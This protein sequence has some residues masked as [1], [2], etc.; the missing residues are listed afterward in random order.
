[1]S[2][3]KNLNGLAMFSIVLFILFLYFNNNR[4]GF[5]IPFSAPNP[6]TGKPFAPRISPAQ[7][8]ANEAAR[9]THEGKTN[10]GR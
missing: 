5:S 4:E 3:K 10:P 2:I 1:M 6:K 8:K 7:F 9:R